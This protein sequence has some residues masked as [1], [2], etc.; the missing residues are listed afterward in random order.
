M[1]E[2]ARRFLMAYIKAPANDFVYDRVPVGTWR[3]PVGE[4]ANYNLA[5]TPYWPDTL[6]KS[7][8][9]R[10]RRKFSKMLNSRRNSCYWT[11]ILLHLSDV[12][13]IDLP[14]ARSSSQPDHAQ[15]L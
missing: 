11:G 3:Q 15:R 8:S 14:A 2:Q 5:D 7:A 12:A 6:Y 1:F 13:P 10:E 9:A 4:K